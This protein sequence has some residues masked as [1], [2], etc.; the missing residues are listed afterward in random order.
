[1]G[2]GHSGKS[3]QQLGSIASSATCAI[4]LVP[5]KEGSCPAIPALQIR[6][7]PL[8]ETQYFRR[9]ISTSFSATLIKQKLVAPVLVWCK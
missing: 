4:P 1:M 5:H 9:K 8:S 3:G 6:E 2:H 7:W